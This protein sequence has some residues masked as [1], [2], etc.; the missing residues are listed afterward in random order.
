MENEK[1][2]IVLEKSFQLAL[3][4]INLTTELRKKNRI[5]ADQ[6][7]R[8]GTSVGA[9]LN[10]AQAAL[11]KKEF[12]AKVSIA[13]KEIRETKYWLL[14]LTESNLINKEVDIENLVDD[15]IK[16]ITKIIKTS[17]ENN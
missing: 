15:I 4:I 14:L 13:A 10:E 7:L 2:N 3:K 8:S 6:I 17:Q 16:I 12:I 9:N 1:K 11:T 5:L